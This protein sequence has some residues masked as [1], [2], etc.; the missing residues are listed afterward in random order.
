MDDKTKKT[1]FEKIYNEIFPIV[2]KVSYHITKDMDA[3]QDVCQDAF[4][5][6][7]HRVENFPGVEDAKFWLIRVVKNLSFNYLEHEK[8]KNRA[9]DKMK[10]IP[11]FTDD[12]GEKQ[13][14]KKEAEEKVN[15][16]LE[17]LPENL[18]APIILREF[19]GMNYK[20]IGAALGIS[21]SNV[22]IRIFR[23]RE[24]LGKLLPVGEVYV[25]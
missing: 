2:I 12:T 10:H 24:A 14:L 22:K 7:Y 20:E 16:A 15:Q 5:K 19:G 1:F 18:K 23:A 6:L 21:E 3:A 11:S 8:V 13:L 9:F 17:Q 4:I 25:P